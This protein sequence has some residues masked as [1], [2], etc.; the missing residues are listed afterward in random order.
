MSEHELARLDDQS[1]RGSG[2]TGSW[3]LITVTYNSVE[4]LRRYWSDVE[5][6]PNC[7][8]IVVDNNSSDDSTGVAKELGAEVIHL[9]RNMGFAAANNIG[10]RATSSEFVAFV[11]P[12][13]T[14]V[15]GDLQILER[16]LTRSKSLVAPQLVNDDGSLQPNGRGCPY[17]STMI[18]HRLAPKRVPEYRIYGTPGESS[19]VVWLIGAVVAGKRTVLESLGPWD[20]RF[21]M[22]YEDS[23]LGLRAR[24]KGIE[25]LIVGDVRWV[26][27]WARETKSLKL[28]PWV[29]EVASLTRFYIRYPG[30]V[31]PIRRLPRLS[32]HWKVC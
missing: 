15:C 8:W 13:V 28:Q 32:N 3:T 14:P 26:H 7:K 23:D 2:G 18:L 22:Y 5:L 11:N 9:A 10:F 31:S 17:L 24:S 6:N 1:G 25:S 20:E 27:G 16:Y 30:L 12:D 21:F 29:H 4:K 19:S